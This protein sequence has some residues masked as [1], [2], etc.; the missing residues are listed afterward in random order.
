M[1]RFWDKVN[2]ATEDECWEWQGFCNSGGY[3]KIRIAGKSVSVHRVAYELSYGEIPQSEGYHGTVVRHSCD[4]RSCCNPK[5]LL[6]GTQRD[7]C[8]DAVERGRHARAGGVPPK[9]NDQSALEMICKYRTGRYTYAQLSRLYDISQAQA[10]RI[11]SGQRRGY[12]LE[13]IDGIQVNNLPNIT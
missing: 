5:H 1:K 11:C 6:L 10:R 13:K 3:G 12:L 7:N 8:I 4:N 9:L 2:Q